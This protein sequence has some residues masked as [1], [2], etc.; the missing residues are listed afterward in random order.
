MS[1]SVGVSVGVSVSS[2]SFWWVG[3]GVIKIPR[4]KTKKRKKC[5]RGYI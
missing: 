3:E 4:R 2:L 1:E 5:G